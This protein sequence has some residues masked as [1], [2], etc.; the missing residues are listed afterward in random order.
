MV[1]TNTAVVDNPALT[2]RGWPGE[3][4]IR[5][6]VDNKGRIPSTSQILNDEAETIIYCDRLKEG[7][8]YSNYVEVAEGTEQLPAIMADLHKRDVTSL[9]VEGG[10]QL[11]SSFIEC[12]LWDEARVFTGTPDF[13]E[14]RKAPQLGSEHHD[15]EDVGDD[16]LRLYYNKT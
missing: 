8:Q 10:Q 5:I 7:A 14:G 2:A 6:T 11:L 3:N 15:E 1:G 9:M 4:P 16:T 12:R 13:I